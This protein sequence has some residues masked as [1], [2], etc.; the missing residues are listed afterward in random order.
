MTRHFTYDCFRTGVRCD[1]Q[2]EVTG[3]TTFLELC[4]LLV[5]A[6]RPFEG[7]KSL[8]IGVMSRGSL[9]VLDRNAKVQVGRLLPL[10]RSAVG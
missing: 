8:S 10:P 6:L 4:D 5:A 2:V 7:E 1:L 3:R 9:L